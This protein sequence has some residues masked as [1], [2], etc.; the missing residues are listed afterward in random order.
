[1][2]LYRSEMVIMPHT[3]D[4]ELYGYIKHFKDIYTAENQGKL[5]FVN[6]CHETSIYIIRRPEQKT[7]YIEKTK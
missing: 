5:T 7:Q 1:M 4:M 2:N 3:N 6:F